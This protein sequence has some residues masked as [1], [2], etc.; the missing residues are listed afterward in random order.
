[1]LDRE[2]IHSFPFGLGS[3]EGGCQDGLERVSGGRLVGETDVMRGLA[4]QA[5][6]LMPHSHDVALVVIAFLQYVRHASS[7]SVTFREIVP[8]TEKTCTKGGCRISKL[9]AG[10]VCTYPLPAAQPHVLE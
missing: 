9:S 8:K 7:K 6:Q 2:V 10:L 1:M 4:Y 3:A 5:M